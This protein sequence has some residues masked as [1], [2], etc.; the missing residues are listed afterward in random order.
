MYTIV[1]PGIPNFEHSIAYYNQI[2][3]LAN[4]TGEAASSA[5]EYNRAVPGWPQRYNVK[6]ESLLKQ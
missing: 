5:L 3:S 4:P 1:R 2:I 6:K